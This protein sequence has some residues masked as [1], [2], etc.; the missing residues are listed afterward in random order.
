MY[1]ISF[2]IEQFTMILYRPFHHYMQLTQNFLG[3]L[4]FMC[5]TRNPAQKYLDLGPATP[6]DGLSETCA[7]TNTV[8]PHYLSVQPARC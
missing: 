3:L 5:W 8:G 7:A 1:L 6:T 2:D 4:W